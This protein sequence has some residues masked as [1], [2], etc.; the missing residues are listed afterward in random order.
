M[1]TH[2]NR[3]HD[4]DNAAFLESGSI[5]IDQAH[6]MMVEVRRGMTILTTEGQEAGKVAAVII[7]RHD[8]EVTH[9]LLSRVSQIPEY[10]LVPIDFIEQVR[11]ENVLLLIFKQVVNSLPVWH[12]A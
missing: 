5:Y 1:P 4:E 11:E 3:F 8:R 12:G 7:N 10:R 2:N 9:I 6:E